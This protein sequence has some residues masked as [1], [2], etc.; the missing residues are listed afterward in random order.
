V[1][2][3]IVKLLYILHMS[4]NMVNFGPLAAE[5][6]LPDCGSPA[7]FNG[8]RLLASLLHRRH[9]PQANQTLH[10]VWL[11]PR[12]VHGVYI[13]FSGLLSPKGF[14]VRCKI[15]S[16]TTSC[17]VLYWHSSSGREPTLRRGTRNGIKELSPKAP[18]I[19]GR[20]AITLGIGPHSSFR[21][22][23][24]SILQTVQDKDIVNN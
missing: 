2:Q 6:G 13:Y 22:V 8:F 20:A 10:N 3:K 16:A 19:F 4:N 12:L 14:F 18:P 24:D 21:L 15:H 1:N 9:S 17:P 11:S 7:N 5:I 23:S